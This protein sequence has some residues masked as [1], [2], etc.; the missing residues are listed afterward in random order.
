MQ[1]WIETAFDLLQQDLGEEGVIT[2]LAEMGCSSAR[3]EKLVCFL[4]L[5]CGRT[6]LADSGITFSSA[7]RRLREDGTVGE[8]T[9][10]AADADWVAIEQ[11]LATHKKTRPD[12]VRVVGMQSAEFDAINKAL[13]GGSK[14]SNLVG[15]RS[16]FSVDVSSRRIAMAETDL[17]GLL[18]PKLGQASPPQ[19]PIICRKG[20]QAI[21][22]KCLSSDRVWSHWSQRRH[23]AT[24]PR[25][26][27]RSAGTRFQAHRRRIQ[28]T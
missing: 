4:P 27:R 11:W 1:D 7:F 20:Q 8:P 21:S 23:A 17:V 3:A 12:A 24:V 10:L 15:F 13:F 5:A 2:R 22:C 19:E 28:G 6:L 26:G 14:L 25:N 16:D 9:P 18:A